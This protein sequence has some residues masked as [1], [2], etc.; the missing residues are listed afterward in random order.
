[1]RDM[2]VRPDQC[3][4]H[5]QNTPTDTQAWKTHRRTMLPTQH[6]PFTDEEVGRAVDIKSY[7]AGATTSHTHT[8]RLAVIKLSEYLDAGS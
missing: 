7:E 1:M 8:D 3:P 2:R 5:T 4:T 6:H